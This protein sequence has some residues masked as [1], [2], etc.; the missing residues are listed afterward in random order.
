LNTYLST[1]KHVAL[2]S[3]LK[4]YLFTNETRSIWGNNKGLT[5]L[6]TFTDDGAKIL[7]KTALGRISKSLIKNFGSEA[8]DEHLDEDIKNFTNGFYN[9]ETW[10]SRNYDPK[11]SEYTLNYGINDVINGLDSV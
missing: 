5:S 9:M 1:F 6:F 7:N 8:L 3:T 2:N 11:T 4:D 10:L